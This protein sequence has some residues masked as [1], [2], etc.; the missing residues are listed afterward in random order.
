ML[1]YS[2]IVSESVDVTNNEEQD[3]SVEKWLKVTHKKGEKG[4]LIYSQQ[5][6]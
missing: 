4:C 2:I 3:M 1:L 5:T 6:K